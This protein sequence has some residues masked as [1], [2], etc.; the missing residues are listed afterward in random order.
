MNLAPRTSALT[1]A[2]I[3]LTSCAA[4]LPLP[5]TLPQLSVPL[6]AQF[7]L[8]AAD[9][10]TWFAVLVADGPH[11]RATLLSPLGV[12]GARLVLTDGAWVKDGFQVPDRAREALLAGLLF[13]LAD[14]STFERD[15]PAA[16]QLAGQRELCFGTPVRCWR[17][18]TTGSAEWQLEL[19]S[20]RWRIS[21]LPTGGAE[22]P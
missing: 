2:L 14:T 3:L 9:Q 15:Y 11:L 4:Q 16:T 21:L 13:A 19:D 20:T 8:A 5:A 1:A 22:T 12:P 7:Y 18:K 6:P 17:S 10:E